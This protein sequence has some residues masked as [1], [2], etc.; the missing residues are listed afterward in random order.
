MK[1]GVCLTLV[2][3][4][5]I[6]SPAFCAGQV[7][8]NEFVAANT[9]TLADEDGDKSDWIELYNAGATAVD[10]DGWC[11]TDDAAD[12]CKWRFP[13]VALAGGEYL[14]VFASGK[15]RR[16]PAAEL[17][18]SFRMSADGEYLAL[19]MPDGT[20]VAQ[21]LAPAY[22][23]QKEDVSYGFA[24]KVA[25]VLVEGSAARVSVPT[26][27]GG[28]NWTAVDFDDGSWL[29]A[30]LGVGFD[31]E[32][33]PD[34]PPDSVRNLA[35]DGTATQSSTG[36]T[37]GASLAIDGSLGDFT[38][39][40]A[41]VNLPATWE[42]DLG[43]TFFIQKIVLHNRAGCCP[44]RLRD[45]TVS[46]LDS[47]GTNVAYESAL[48]NP[49]NVLGG[50]VASGG[51]ATLT[52][53]LVA[54]T[55][56]VVEG[57]KVRV[58]R[59][60]DPDLSGSDGDGNSDEAD[61]LSLAEVEV[62]GSDQPPG[63]RGLIA[64]DLEER[65]HGVNASV[66]VRIPF[67]VEDPAA[68]ESLSLR[69]RYDDGFIAYINGQEAARRNAPAV[70]VWN[71]AAPGERA[72][73]DALA[74]EEIP[75]SAALAALRPGKN[76]LAV[77]GL[78]HA[79]SDPD[80]L[81]LPELTAVWGA[82]REL[83]Y[84]RTPT[85]G[86]PND[87]SSIAGFVGE[88]S[89]GQE[90][91]FYQEPFELTLA[92]ATEGAEIRYTLDGTPPG[93]TNGTLYTS[94]LVIE[95]T[96]AV[97][98]A[99]F[100]TGLEPSAVGT[101]TYFF[102]DDVIRQDAQA[103]RAAGFPSSWGGVT[104]DYGM[105]MRVIG[106]DGTDSFGGKY[107]ATIKSDLLAVPTLSIVTN[108]D[109][110]FGPN[111]IYTNSTNEGPAWERPCSVELIYPHG[112][113]GFQENAGIRTQGGAFRSHGLTKKHSLRLLFK[114][115]YGAAKLRY[116]IFGPGAP[117]R[118][119]TITLRAN[120]ND[121]WQ[122]DAAGA[123]PVYV[124]DS[125]GRM[126][127]RAM[128]GQSS[129]EI[130][131]HLYIN[132]I[133]WGLYNPCERP[134][135][136]FCATYYG[137]EA[138]Q[139]DS[140]SNSEVSQG[141]YAAWNTLTSMAAQVGTQG[142][143][144]VAAFLKLEGKN[145]DGT[146]NPAW[147]CYLDAVNYADYMLTNIYVGNTDWPN[148]NWWM[149]RARVE[150]T[151]FK[152]FMWDSEWSMGIQSDLSTN[153][154][155]ASEAIAQPWS[156]VR[157]NAEF[158]QLVADRAQR[159]FFPGGALYVDVTRPQW[160]PTHPERNAPAAHF[161]ALAA[162]IDRAI[163]AESARWGDQHATRSYTRDEHWAVERDNLLRNYLPQRS[164]VVLG[165]LRAAGLFPQ[166]AAP[167]FSQRGGDIHTPF[168]LSMQA[169]SGV[170]YYTLDG[171]DPRLPGGAVAPTAAVLGGQAG[172]V[173]LVNAG[174]D[175]RVLV[176]GDGG[177]GTSW[178]APD[179]DDAAWLAGTTGVGYERATGYETLIATN[180]EAAMYDKASS[181]YLRIRFEVA[182]PSVY[183]RLALR[184]RY[185]DGF[186][187]YLNGTAVLARNAPAEPLWSS[188][189]TASRDPPEAV[190][191]EDL[192]IPDGPTL[193][194][195]GVNVLA[196]HGLNSSAAS[197][198]LLILPVLDASRS[199]GDDTVMLT[200]SALVQARARVGETWSALQEA[201][202][203]AVR[204]LDALRITEI[205]YNPREEG[206]IDGDAF[207]FLE[208]QNRGDAAL[209]LSGVFFARGVQYTFPEGTV[210]EPGRFVVL[211]GDAD[212]FGRRYG[213]VPA[214][215]GA[216]GGNL[217]NSGDVLALCAPDGEIIA[218]VLYDDVPPWPV[219]A[220]GFG[221]SVV[222]VDPGV[223]PEVGDF[224]A[225]KASALP[226]GSP[227]RD[228]ADAPPAAGLQ[229]PG[230][231]N[232]DGALNIADA[233]ALL[234]YLFGGPGATLPCS[235]DDA[236]SGGNLALLD[237][238]GD[239][240]V[241]IADAIQLLGYLFSFGRPHLLGTGCVEIEGCPSVCAR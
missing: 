174:A 16:D 166:V 175:V 201:G 132:G 34:L 162:G 21:E 190:T 83:R 54:A 106:Q 136:S 19:V 153:V 6:S 80:F 142:A 228:D 158:R 231:L 61:V 140:L 118:F 232:Q 105:D 73:V 191:A 128:G 229:R 31:T 217:S 209:D 115:S 62:L 137:G 12:P 138:E 130:F 188:A 56:A 94:P 119:D 32:Q 178:T 75:F 192:E 223:R 71:S 170:V 151:G 81:L 63:Y 204:S 152:F 43:G 55:G 143:A 74:G 89:F 11:L 100:K 224:S 91:G 93:E 165:H 164:N 167:T 113:A 53:D 127:L 99:A 28:L 241:N 149:G 203:R 144:A 124:R 58:V 122:W 78:N 77:H 68:L 102:L 125:F 240:G 1:H 200:G 211:A 221:R 180:V 51:P 30:T 134:D 84:F 185:D 86:G 33:G 168:T 108:I 131:A 22:P 47:S 44:S 207:E 195:A 234:R 237:G 5:V 171:T 212:A 157:M 45:I 169:P 159:H 85:P 9:A 70:A 123:K 194:R 135:E 172:W 220:D 13:A 235:G 92:C 42:V 26:S 18:T 214:L 2:L 17:H 38:H 219:D 148:K 177:L 110:F 97:R 236:R 183:A 139:W 35:L 104:P 29:A 79:A 111:G 126:T 173:T 197:N 154:I 109:G 66:Y 52:V 146:R 40:S 196:L 46:I 87:S 121:G 145:P 147:E 213:R 96:T 4:G 156:R 163:V 193:L 76:V 238:N 39:T 65:L 216:Y 82:A 230:D 184:M 88:V 225:W 189:A 215:L 59:T 7:V 176:P 141:S 116:P 57:G 210:V 3:F 37:Y 15:D 179:F 101:H 48:L 206:T 50:G 36:F 64:T 117:D 161:A 90:R 103:T 208:L 227:G 218:E 25:T 129:R 150:S 205:M 10:L 182:D 24:R 187:A 120:S 222:P 233:I 67:Q 14:V 8:I 23:P 69:M 49:E 60:P 186:V 107:A 27:G 112:G 114:K 133:Y 160:D 20:T 95:R 41:G 198:D 199:A 239:A 202:F 226:D 72:D 155:S 98:A 181:V